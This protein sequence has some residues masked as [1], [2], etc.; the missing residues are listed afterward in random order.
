MP[1]SSHQELPTFLSAEPSK[2]KRNEELGRPNAYAAPPHAQAQ[3]QLRRAIIKFP[4][5]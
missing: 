2:K 5:G 1:S 4:E 3:V